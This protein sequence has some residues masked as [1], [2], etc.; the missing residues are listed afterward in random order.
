MKK[1]RSERLRSYRPIDDQNTQSF[2]CKAKRFVPLC[3]LRSKGGW[4]HLVVDPVG[5]HEVHGGSRLF[6]GPNEE[7][8]LW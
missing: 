8:R 4:Q 7:Q 6:E 2:I 5:V 3:T 1:T